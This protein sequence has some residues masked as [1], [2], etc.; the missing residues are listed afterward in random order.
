MNEK[1][2][3]GEHNQLGTD[4]WK[5]KYC[6]ENESFEEWITRISGGNPEIARLIKEKKFLFGGRIL[7]NRGLQNHGRC[8]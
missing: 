6:F 4:I 8:V 7:S 1:E 3:L 5:K 2:W